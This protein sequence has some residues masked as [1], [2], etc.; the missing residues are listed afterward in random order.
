[1]RWLSATDSV[2]KKQSCEGTTNQTTQRA[3]TRCYKLV[4]T[5]SGY[6][7]AEWQSPPSPLLANRTQAPQARTD[8][9]FKPNAHRIEDLRGVEELPAG[10]RHLT[11]SRNGDGGDD[12]SVGRE[13]AL[14]DDL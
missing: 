11:R 10:R 4:S 12:A 9:I 7:D 1:M 6:R 3:L 8:R 13:V 14:R 5:R 2:K